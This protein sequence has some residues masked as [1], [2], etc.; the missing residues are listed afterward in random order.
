MARRGRRC[1]PRPGCGRGQNAA[2]RYPQRRAASAPG[3]VPAAAGRTP[4]SRTAGPASGAGRSRTLPVRRNGGVTRR[5]GIFCAAASLVSTCNGSTRMASPFLFHRISHISFDISVYRIFLQ[6]TSGR[7]Q[8]KC[9]AI[10]RRQSTSFYVLQ[11]IT[12]C[13]GAQPEPPRS[14]RP[15]SYSAGRGRPAPARCT[16]SR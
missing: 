8:K 2:Q 12:C 4:A 3:S 14:P 5:V 1:S 7:A 10:P 13:C 9:P 6:E 15:S 16:Q 11:R